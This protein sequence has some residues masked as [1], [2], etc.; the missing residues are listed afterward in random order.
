MTSHQN[1]ALEVV[2]EKLPLLESE[3]ERD[4]LAM[5]MLKGEAESARQLANKLKNFDATIQSGS[6]KRLEEALDASLREI[7][8][9]ENKI[10]QLRA[11]F[12]ALKHLE[13]Q[14]AL[15][16]TCYHRYH[17]IRKYDGI[18]SADRIPLESQQ[19]VS[20][21]LENW[22]KLM[23]KLLFD[24]DILCNLLKVQPD[25][26]ESTVAARAAM[27]SELIGLCE[28]GAKLRGH[29]LLP[30]ILNLINSDSPS[31][32]NQ[33]LVQL[34]EWLGT[35]RNRLLALLTE[36]KKNHWGISEAFQLLNELGTAPTEL[37]NEALRAEDKARLLVSS[38]D[39]FSEIVPSKS[40]L[41]EIE[42][43][44]SKLERGA[45]S[46]L[47][48]HMPWGCSRS[49]AKL[50]RMGFGKLSFGSCSIRLNILAWV[51]QWSV[52]SVIRFSRHVSENGSGEKIEPSSETY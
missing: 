49:C 51:S 28:A 27:S 19:V 40:K 32:L 13:R 12:S 52:A 44:I 5:S 25:T 43:T 3:L 24:Y 11:R 42:H 36:S 15:T 9:C 4:Y 26:D 35:I 18:H 47:Q 39:F 37:V 45:K 1:K 6:R 29:P 38:P 33:T 50:E 7:E 34:V 46:W 23:K 10:Q 31:A 41:N 22:S 17:E 14:S 16:K 20:E 8:D 21:A 48:W 2:T 30:R